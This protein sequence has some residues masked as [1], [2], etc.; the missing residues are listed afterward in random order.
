[1]AKVEVTD[2]L[3]KT[4]QKHPRILE[5]RFIL[6]FDMLEREYGYA[7]AKKIIS[8]FCMAFNRN[9]DMLNV[10]L[11]KRFDI[12]RK[13]KT[14]KIKWT[15][16]VV[17]MGMCY[18]E[19]PYKIAKDYLVISPSNFYRS[20]MANVYDVNTFLTDE[21]LRG[22]DDE[23]KITGNYAYKNEVKGFLDVVDGLRQTLCKWNVLDKRKVK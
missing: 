5:V 22:L 10:I 14:S 9:E 18:G 16:E 13:Q 4:Y 1:M 15:Q 21:W 12:K 7:G 2:E 6:F 23:V 19:T 3:L 8:A 11:N 17:F 20:T